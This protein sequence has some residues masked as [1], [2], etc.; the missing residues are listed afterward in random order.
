VNSN[1][2]FSLWRVS[3]AL[4][5]G[6]GSIFVL[7]LSLRG[8]D[9]RLK[10]S[11]GSG[12]RLKRLKTLVHAWRSI[13][14][15]VIALITVLMVLHELGINI[16]PILASAGVVGLALSLGAQTVIKDLLGGVII[17]SE[18]QFAIGDIIT[19]G[20]FTGTVERITL[21]ATYLRDNDCKLT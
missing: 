1:I 4:L 11:G 20:Q 6:L 15:V 14:H 7:H 19:V 3:I 8:F 10:K 12:E 2:W 9:R 16:T 21:R 5:V 18:N 17:L 13:G